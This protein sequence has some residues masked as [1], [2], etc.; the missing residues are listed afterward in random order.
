MGA[1]CI[2]TGRHEK[3]KQKT[4]FSV[5]LHAL[6]KEMLFSAKCLRRYCL[7]EKQVLYNYIFKAGN[8][9]SAERKL[10][11][12]YMFILRVCVMSMRVQQN[13]YSRSTRG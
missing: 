12:V 7:F 5:F 9:L 2:G 6:K 3:D 13:T 4:V 1:R 10:V 11:S 8:L